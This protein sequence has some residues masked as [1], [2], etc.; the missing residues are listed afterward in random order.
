MPYTICGAVEGLRASIMMKNRALASDIFTLAQ[1]AASALPKVAALARDQTVHRY[2]P[3]A[4]GA[5]A[6]SD[7]PDKAAKPCG[8][9]LRYLSLLNYHWNFL[10]AWLGDG[11]TVKGSADCG[12]IMIM[13]EFLVSVKLGRLL[14]HPYLSNKRF[15][16][17]KQSGS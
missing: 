10:A 6:A 8:K 9:A 12:W 13:E 3:G 16:I 1:A 5:L 2:D 14:Q 4:N 17:C 7:L 15:W 11:A